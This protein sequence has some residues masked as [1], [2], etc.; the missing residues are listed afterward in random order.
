MRLVRGLESIQPAMLEVLS[1]ADVSSIIKGRLDDQSLRDIW[2][3]GEVTNFKCHTS[4]HCYF[5]LTEQRNTKTYSI[6]C[7]MW[8]G[9][10]EVLDFLPTNGMD[11]LVFGYVDYYPQHGRTQFYVRDMTHAGEGEKHLLVERWRLE[12]AAEG[13]FAFERKRP[14]PD[15]PK[16][17][18]VVTSPMGAVIEDIKNIIKRR[19]PTEIVLSPTPVQ[20]DGV[21][22]SIAAA[23]RRIDSLVDVIIV[24]RGGG[25]FED[26]FPF[27]HPDVVRA[28]SSCS[29]PVVS[30]IGHEVDI[31]MS[32]LAADVRAPTPSVAAELVVKDRALLR[33]DLGD[34]QQVL[35]QGIHKKLQHAEAEMEDL[36]LHFHPRRLLRVIS[37][38]RLELADFA[39]SLSR[40]IENR[41]IREHLLLKQI[42]STIEARN[43]TGPL[44][45]GYCII[46]KDGKILK[47]IYEMKTEDA[48]R[49]KMRDGCSTAKIGRVYYDREL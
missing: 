14:L 49:I 2:V 48:I 3:R 34:M 37:E 29:V 13:L 22:H 4:G 12:L 26:L 42:S 25:S 31:T 43:P 18:G 21:H 6:D 9:D 45:R 47:S 10:V 17:I 5:S 39:E 36:H 35:M 46:E 32:D 19:F 8:K 7:V 28:I 44:L 30:A 16:K 41:F 23:I 38:R 1:V 40:T 20:G 24:A 15:F 27:N 11:V 33:L